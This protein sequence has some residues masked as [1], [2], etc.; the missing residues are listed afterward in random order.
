MT[1]PERVLVVGG[2]AREHALAWRLARDESVSEVHVAPGNPGMSDV[3]LVHSEADD[4]DAIVALARRLEVDL[5][6]VGPEAPLAAG[7]ADELIE[8]DV[9]VFGPTRAAA[10]LETSK[11][12]CRA[13]A[14]IA[15]IPMAEGASFAQA[16]E[17]VSYARALGGPVVV[18]ADGLAGGKG[19]T[20]CDTLAEAE[21]GIRAALEDG[22]FGEAGRMVVIER[23]L[24]GQEA[25]LMAICDGERAI[26]LP[27]VRDYKRVAD[28]DRGANTGGMGAF[29]PIPE[30]DEADAERILD[31]FHLRAVAEMA[32]RGIPFRGVLYAGLM[33]TDSGPRLLE[34]NVRFGDPEAQACLPRIDGPFAATLLAA[35]SGDLSSVIRGGGNG[36]SARG[37]LTVRTEAAV[38]VVVATR[39]Y[40]RSAPAAGAPIDGVSDARRSGA[41]V[42]HGATGSRDG[43]LVTGRGRVL[44]V[45]GR[46]ADVAHA[47][48]R[49]YDGVARIRFDGMLYR[50]DIGIVSGWAEPALAAEPSPEPGM[51]L[52]PERSDRAELTA[53]AEPA[54]VSVT[55]TVPPEA[56]SLGDAQDPW[57][58]EAVAPPESVE[59]LEPEPIE[60]FEPEPVEP[61]EPEPVEPFAPEPVEPVERV[62]PAPPPQDE[63]DE[64]APTRSDD[65]RDAGSTVA[66][67]VGS[68]ND[69]KRLDE[70]REVFEWFG[71]VYEV[72][73]ASAHRAPRRVLGLAEGAA[74][75][76]I[77]VLIAGAG[78]AAALPG[79]LAASTTL[80][81]IGVP[82]SSPDLGG[83]DALLSAVQMPRGV[84]VATVAIDGVAN[85]AILAAEI[86]ALSDARL[87]RRLAEFKARLAAGADV[88]RLVRGE[89]D[90]PEGGDGVSAER[91]AGAAAE[92]AR[93]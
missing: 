53:S 28:G 14:E 66:V 38:G 55:A 61:F 54:L 30:L 19:V 82:F 92:P 59:P 42:F 12:F 44:T 18:K 22:A 60:P 80:P 49:A 37:S 33:L 83:M 41:L 70:A 13:V 15:G 3:A 75:R 73:V 86:C 2:G 63:H 50:K 91:S 77:R 7:L 69:L 40:P 11:T 84:P 71:I 5:V 29:S 47:R 46:D 21:V 4:L 25:T 27:V 32:R 85:A 6:V 52:T 56:P 39:G 72:H 64:D 74:D 23:R 43:R 67:V 10:A 36:R 87:A 17:A 79:V 16:D 31:A 81:V 93:R 34:F 35:A 51:E 57:R 62:A 26:A 9:P 20:V 68:A 88:M 8:A 24:V 1:A 58:A 76:G 90:R 45:V 65:P 48:E 78:K 89:E